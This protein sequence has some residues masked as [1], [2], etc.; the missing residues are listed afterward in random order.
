MSAPIL[1]RFANK[2]VI[3]TGGGSGIGQAVV[4]RLA[5]EGAIVTAV[6]VNE[7]GLVEGAKQVE[8]IAVAGGRSSFV[9]GSVSNEDSV[10]KIVQDV[11]DREGRLDALINVAGI[12]RSNNTLDTSLEQFMEPI[13]VNLVGTFLFCREAM[14]HLLKTKGNIVNTAS[15]SAQYG[16]PYMAGYAAS[17]GGVESMTKALAWEYIRQGVRINAV[18]PGGVSTPLTAAQEGRMGTLDR[19]LFQ[20]L[21]RP[22]FQFGMPDQVASV[23]A[24][25]A[26]E[27]GGFMTGEIVKV[28]GGVHN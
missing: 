18:A 19:S 16:H 1:S 6:D 8:Q 4:R 22:D 3:V 14:P 26:S 28:D 2:V 25:L 17:K 21:T 23:F 13:H 10:K 24:M 20:R 15:T 7:T 5:S 11:V 9:V 12:L 27:D